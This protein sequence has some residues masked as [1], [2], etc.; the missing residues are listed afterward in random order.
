MTVQ[1]IHHEEA[2]EGLQQKDEARV[3]KVGA[4]S[5]LPTHPIYRLT[6]QHLGIRPH[7]HKSI[8]TALPGKVLPQNPAK[9][10]I[11]QRDLYWD[12]A[13]RPALLQIT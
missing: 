10:H 8:E 11:H 9:R 5:Y 13:P 6:D 3:P 4:Q 7:H 12:S 2:E 1:L